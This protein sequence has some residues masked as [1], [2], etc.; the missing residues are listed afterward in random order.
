MSQEVTLKEVETY[1]DSKTR[2]LLHRYGPGPRVH[3]HTGIADTQSEFGV[4]P[5]E[6]KKDIVA[7]QERILYY[8]AAMWN[9]PSFLSGNIV[10]IGCGLG[11]G[12]IFWA[13]E[14][15]AHVTAVTCVPS[16]I[17]I[18]SRFAMQAGVRAS[19]NPLLCDALEVPG[20]DCYDAAVAIESSCHMNRPALFQ[21]LATLLP[22]GG[23]VFIADYF[24]EEQDYQELWSRHWRAPIG[25]ID[26][27]L[28]AALYAGF[29]ADSV[30]D[31]SHRT[32]SFWELT[33]TLIQM[34]S[35]D[36][37]HERE[38]QEKYEK[39]LRAHRMVLRGLST[40]GMKY[41]LLSFSKLE[42]QRYQDSLDKISP[43]FSL[44]A[45]HAA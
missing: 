41:A 16:H 20:E 8:A 25:T 19:I 1:Y 2:D 3:Y 33:S 43:A 36:N 10:D 38:Q 21:R 29:Q 35:L 28:S 18:V 44:P 31:I 4:F 13:Q 34:E 26:E 39:S 23:R 7:S 17:E 32:E 27:Y 5:Q 14:F 11:G 12:S 9:A 40:G 6:I 37:E 42:E 30:K 22:T 24:F 45:E 15:G